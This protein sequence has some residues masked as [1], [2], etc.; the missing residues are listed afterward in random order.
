MKYKI[1]VAHPGKQHSLRMAEAIK[2]QEALYKYITTIYDKKKS[3]FM[4][5]LKLILNKDNKKRANSRRSNEIKDNDVKQICVFYGL[6]ILIL[7][8]IKKLKNFYIKFNNFLINNF[9]RKVAKVAVKINVDMVISYD[10]NSNECFKKIKKMNPHIKTVL[11]ASIANRLY[12]KIIYKKMAEKE[13]D[14]NYYNIGE[15][16]WEKNFD[17]K[18]IDEIKNTDYFIV[19]SNF[20]KKSY[21]EFG[22]NPEKIFIVPYGVNIF[23]DI[24]KEKIEIKN[25]VNFLFVGQIDYRKGI[26]LLLEVFSEMNKENCSLT[27]VGENQLPKEISKKYENIKNIYFTGKVTQDKLKDI[28]SNSDVFVLPTLTEGMALVGLEAMGCGLPVICTE[29]SG[30]NDL[31]TNETGFTIE[32]GNKKLL[33]EKME[34]FLNNQ[35]KILKM[36]E[37]SRIIANR[38]TWDKY[39]ENIKQVIQIILDK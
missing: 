26:P 16:L 22:V 12:S 23:N 19:P 27:L 11:D 1:I 20:V 28:Y 4:K 24:K 32:A 31:I 30:I 34:W 29:N 14:E 21:I 5:V 8:R 3:F 33:K 9:G 7:V 37:N 17:K 35:D 10:Y 2:E 38:Y 36:G 18:C 39:K 6:L 25:K 15:N 13:Q